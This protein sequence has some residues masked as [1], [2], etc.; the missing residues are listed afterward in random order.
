[1]KSDKR[2]FPSKSINSKSEAQVPATT[3]VK[4]HPN[5]NLLNCIPNFIV[6]SNESCEIASTTSPTSL[7]IF[8]ISIAASSS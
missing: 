7:F 6:S 3:S 5:G 1:M 4:S 8:D 2:Q